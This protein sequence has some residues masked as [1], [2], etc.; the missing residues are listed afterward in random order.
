MSVL[1]Q[2]NSGQQETWLAFKCPLRVKALRS[3]TLVTL[4]SILNMTEVEI[5]FACNKN[6]TELTRQGNT[7]LLEYSVNWKAA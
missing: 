2:K 3:L 1:S 6:T 5:N 7:T 4:A